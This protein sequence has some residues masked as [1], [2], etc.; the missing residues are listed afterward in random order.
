MTSTASI[1]TKTASNRSP[2]HSAIDNSN[3]SNT[4]GVSPQSRSTGGA[5]SSP[6]THIVL[7]ESERIL[8]TPYLP[9]VAEEQAPVVSASS[10][11]SST[12]EED[13]SENGNV[14]GSNAGKRPAWNKPLNGTSEV[15]TVMGAE[16]W[17][18]LSKSARG[19][20]KSS[21]DSLKG[22]SDGS[23]PDSVS[24]LQGSETIPSSSSPRQ[25]SNNANPNST[26]NHMV[27]ARSRSMKGNSTNS[28]SNDGT[29]QPP[30]MQGPVGEGHLDNS[31]PRDHS[32]RNTQ[33]RGANDHQQQMR[34]SF[35]NRN[36]GLHSRGDSSHHHNLGGRRD[37]DRVNQG[38]NNQRHF[39][40]RDGHMQSQRPFTRF[41]RHPP[42]SSA[43]PP[44]SASYVASSPLQ[45][46][47]NTMGF[48]EFPL[49]VYYAAPR[50]PPPAMFFPDPQLHYNIMKQI[51]YYFSD[52][53]LIK[54]TFLRQNMDDQGW[55]HVTLIAGFKKVAQLTPNI[56]VILDSM[57]NSNVVEVQGDKIRRQNDWKRWIMPPSVQFANVSTAQSSAGILGGHIE[58]ISLE[59]KASNHIVRSGAS[60]PTDAICSSSSSG[61]LNSQS[62]L[63]SSRRLGHVSAQGGVDHSASSPISTK[64]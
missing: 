61:D 23:L 40:G 45:G 9:P 25:S 38:W 30:G 56:Q 49:Q 19:A 16:L 4:K 2:C 35:R 8:A 32:Q 62:E 64:Q 22:L 47:G 59:E 52:E 28:S 15:G 29:S 43:L 57:R 50:M 39:N 24:Q 33:L 21:S 11:A 55:V 63:S 48:P 10:S 34:N 60:I 27:S 17:P 37:Q 14:S 36:G 51:N 12:V 13:F 6:W 1:M 20:T 31:S 54:D 53:N 7:S 5:V 41:M 42:L 44:T 3:S 26:P 46:F 58:S 18:P